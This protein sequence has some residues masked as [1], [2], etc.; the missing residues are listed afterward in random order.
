M[1]VGRTDPVSRTC[2]AVNT[3]DVQ[4]ALEGL[5]VEASGNLDSILRNPQNFI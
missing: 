3:G 1:V 2:G 4:P 5:G